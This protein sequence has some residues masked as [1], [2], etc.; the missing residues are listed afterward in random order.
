[1]R[2]WIAEV[3]E[4]PIAQILAHVALEA[5]DDRYARVLVSPYDLAVLFGIKLGR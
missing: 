3:D 2:G 1:M 4:Q 5:A